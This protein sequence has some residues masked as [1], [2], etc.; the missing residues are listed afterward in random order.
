MTVTLTAIHLLICN[1]LA[2][3]LRSLGND[4]LISKAS[5]P[6]S[7]SIYVTSLC[8]S[9]FICQKVIIQC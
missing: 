2:T 5:G 1:I 9:F 8:L 6:F 7:F 4:V 3:P